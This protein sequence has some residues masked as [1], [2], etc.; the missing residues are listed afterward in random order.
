MRKTANWSGL[1]NATRADNT[2]DFLIVG[3][4][5]TGLHLCWKLKAFDSNSQALIVEKSK[6]CGGRMAT[7]RIGASR[8]DH[9]AQFVKHSPISDEIISLWRELKVVQE[10]RYT[11]ELS[12]CG[13]LGMTAPAKKIAENLNVIYNCKIVRI[14]KE[15][16][17]WV[18]HGENDQLYRTKNVILTA[19]LPQA[20][21]LLHNSEISFDEELKNITY[22]KAISMLIFLSSD[23]QQP[24]GYSDQVDRDIYS[25][26][27]QSAK[28]LSEKVAYTVTLGPEWSESH[29][30]AP[31]KSAIETFKLLFSQKFPGLDFQV[32][33][34]KK[35]RY[36]HPLITDKNPFYQPAEGLF[37]AGDAFGG[38]SINGA[39]HSSLSLFNYLEH[40]RR[41]GEPQEHRPD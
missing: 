32:A 7:R 25:I 37:L 16:G 26:S 34:L 30:E 4:G 5:I 6:S 1:Q 35:W 3:A 9:G 40:N 17:E 13:I 36:S 33:D 31:D 38:P 14:H 23:F 8:F 28:G 19:P 39:L 22:A 10:Y 11:S 18:V 12:Y 20:L 21:E 2:H 29:F 41:R 24:I 15:G 27:S